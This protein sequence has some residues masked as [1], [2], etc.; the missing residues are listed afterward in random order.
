LLKKRENLDFFTTPQRFQEP[1]CIHQ[2]NR[3]TFTLFTQQAWFHKQKSKQSLKTQ[4]EYKKTTPPL[5]LLL[6]YKHCVRNVL[7]TK[8]F[9]ICI[10][11]YY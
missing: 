1:C 11:I 7:V 3:N 6:I 10:L 2:F 5:Q 8:L 4:G 9:V